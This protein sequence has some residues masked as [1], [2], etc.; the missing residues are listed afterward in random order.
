MTACY[1]EGGCWYGKLGRSGI[2]DRETLVW[3]NQGIINS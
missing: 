3:I 1:L 2:G